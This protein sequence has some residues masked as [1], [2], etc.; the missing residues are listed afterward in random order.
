[1]IIMFWTFLSLRLFV[2]IV[3]A[4]RSPWS[5]LSTARLWQHSAYGVVLAPT[6]TFYVKQINHKKCEWITVRTVWKIVII[7]LTQCRRQKW[8]SASQTFPRNFRAE[9]NCWP[10]CFICSAIP[11]IMG[12]RRRCFC[13]EQLAL[14]RHR[15][16]WKHWTISKSHMQ[17]SIASSIMH[18]NCSTRALWTRS[19]AM[20]WRKTIISRIS[21]RAIRPRVS[22]TKCALS[23]HPD[24]TFLYW[25]IISDCTAWMR[26]YCRC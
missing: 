17:W 12:C 24:R 14:A 10:I 1:M 2:Y 25:R 5:W 22:L 26:I 4:A 18:R 8:K 3:T 19:V 15:F 13:T 23:T 20:S 21:H 6:K 9:R 11:P 16:F 7:E